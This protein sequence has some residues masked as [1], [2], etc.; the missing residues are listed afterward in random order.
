MYVIGAIILLVVVIIIIIMMNKENFTLFKSN[1]YPYGATFTSKKKALGIT[2]L[3]SAITYAKKNGY[4]LFAFNLN[5][6]ITEDSNLNDT[7]EN[8]LFFKDS[9]IKPGFN[10]SGLT[11]QGFNIYASDTSKV[12]TLSPPAHIRNYIRNNY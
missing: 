6:T 12:R 9:D 1:F 4:S 7:N 2:N 10:T 11:I 5:P 3:D 8:I